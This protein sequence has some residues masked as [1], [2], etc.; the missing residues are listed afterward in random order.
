MFCV[1]A[2][3]C[4]DCEGK[5]ILTIPSGEEQN[6]CYMYVIAEL[7]RQSYHVTSMAISDIVV[8]LVVSPRVVR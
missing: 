3:F 2:V 6:N 5:L 4:Y 1:A 7:H 8:G